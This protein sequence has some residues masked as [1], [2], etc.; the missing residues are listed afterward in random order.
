MHQ[1][2]TGPN[3]HQIHYL[4]QEQHKEDREWDAAMK[5]G[6]QWGMVG[7]EQLAQQPYSGQREQYGEYEQGGPEDRCDLVT[8]ERGLHRVV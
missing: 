5:P 8:T 4:N 7:H 1:R 3:V 2:T 6:G